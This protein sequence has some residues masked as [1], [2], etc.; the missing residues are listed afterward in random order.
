M[1][2]TFGEAGFFVMD[3]LEEAPGRL[4][5]WQVADGPEDWIGTTIT[6]EIST[7]GDYTIVMF[8]HAGWAEP[9]EGMHHCSTKWAVFLMSLK[10]LLETGKGQAHPHDLKIDNWN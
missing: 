5:R 6:F 9:S 8:K 7:S 2:F 4:V 1:R 10:S 3:V